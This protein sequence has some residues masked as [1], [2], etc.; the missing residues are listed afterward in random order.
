MTSTHSTPKKILHIISQH[1]DATGSGIYIQAMVREAKSTG[2]DNFLVAGRGIDYSDSADID[3]EKSRFVRFKKGALNYHI[4]GMSDIMPYR[5]SRFGI[6]TETEI[7][8][9]EAAFAETVSRTICQFQPN[10]IHSHHLWLVSS[11]VRRLFP[12]IPMVTSCHGSD[13]RQFI[14]CS[15]L[16]EKVLSGCR[17]IDAI[18][19]L[20]KDQKR[21]INRLYGI[22]NDRIVIVGAGYNE[23]L[24]HPQPKPPPSPV[25][26]V[27]AGKLSN[28][29]GVPWLL[30]AFRLL[31][32]QTSL[33]KWKLHLFGSGSG[34]ENVRCLDLARALGD[35]AVVHGAVPQSQLAEA[36]RRAHIL[37]LPSFYEGLPLV[38]LEG[39]ASGCRLVVSDLPGARE[40]LGRTGFNIISFVKPPRLY[41]TDQPYPSDEATF[42]ENLKM[43]II[44]QIKAAYDYPSVDLSPFRKQ[45]DAYTWDGVFKK[46]NDVY[47]SY[48]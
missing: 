38:V 33:P 40:L 45:L 35:A 2:Y 23:A 28:A 30:Q 10:I 6:L 27:Y 4:P 47:R 25:Q 44:K 43:A 41:N 31:T 26:L 18:L 24:F 8:K 21:E 5:S 3:S 16:R 9:Y 1:P 42:I 29:K 37:V 15:H 12:D 14:N 32:G 13:L 39:L 20:S 17:R 36:I 48:A 19:A 22:P 46:V 11:L 34:E 7:E